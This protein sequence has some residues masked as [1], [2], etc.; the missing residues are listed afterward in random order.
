[1]SYLLSKVSFLFQGKR[2]AEINVAEGLKRS[3]ILNS[4]AFQREQVNQATGEAEALV[5][6]AKA[7]ATSVEVLAKAMTQQVLYD[8]K[9]GFSL[10]KLPYKSR[11]VI[12]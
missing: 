8:Y 12:R 7:Q 6:K 5:W 10:P 4:E 1:M 3:R 9:M 2:E 11:S